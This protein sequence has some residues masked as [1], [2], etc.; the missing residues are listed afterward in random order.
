MGRAN[1][2]DTGDQAR[3]RFHARLA[4]H[5]QPMGDQGSDIAQ[6]RIALAHSS[7]NPHT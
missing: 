1:V 5:C 2:R 4:D 7:L 3:Y 6:K